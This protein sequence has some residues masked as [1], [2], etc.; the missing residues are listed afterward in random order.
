MLQGL[1]APL[2]TSTAARGFWLMPCATMAR[3]EK[4]AGDAGDHNLLSCGDTAVAKDSRAYATSHMALATATASHQAHPKPGQHRLST[5]G[6][7]SHEW[8]KKPPKK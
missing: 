5:L 6:T 1:Q 4:A 8:P 2:T 3:V 7:Q